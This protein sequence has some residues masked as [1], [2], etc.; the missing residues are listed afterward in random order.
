MDMITMLII[1][2][3]IL[4]LFASGLLIYVYLRDKTKEELRK[5]VYDWILKAEH[6]YKESGSGKQK[7]KWV[8]QRARAYLPTWTYWF[9]TEE[10]LEKLIN[11]WF[12]EVKD[13]LDDGKMNKSNK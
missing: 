6:L 1:I 7:L 10:A 5:A 13:L 4:M 2:A 8:V 3:T 12:A 11:I 9:V